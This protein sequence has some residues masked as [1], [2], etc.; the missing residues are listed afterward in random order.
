MKLLPLN[1]IQIS[2]PKEP[3]SKC[4]E[5]HKDVDNYIHTSLPLT[6]RVINLCEV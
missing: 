1:W 5:F 6:P 4:H 3:I 2:D